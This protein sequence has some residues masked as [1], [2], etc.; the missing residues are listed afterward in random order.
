[1]MKSQQKKKRLGVRSIKFRARTAS[2]MESPSYA[3]HWLPCNIAWRGQLRLGDAQEYFI[4]PPESSEP[5]DGLT[6]RLRGRK[7]CSRELDVRGLGFTWTICQVEEQQ[8]SPDKGGENDDTGATSVNAVELPLSSVSAPAIK[9]WT[10]DVDPQLAEESPMST[11]EWLAV[12]V[13]LH[14]DDESR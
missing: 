6:R 3:A 7:L 5:P 14:G 10:H 9:V 13:A 1:M 11:A 12:M 4:G 8:G 2:N